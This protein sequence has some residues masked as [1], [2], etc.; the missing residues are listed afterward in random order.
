MCDDL[1]DDLGALYESA[2]KTG[3]QE[4]VIAQL[5]DAPRVD[6]VTEPAVIFI[7]YIYDIVV[8]LSYYAFDSSL[9]EKPGMENCNLALDSTDVQRTPGR[10]LEIHVNTFI[11]EM[12]RFMT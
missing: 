1:G 10:S 4:E 12:P 5:S 6:A 11:F 2:M 8:V 3:R 7:N 9:R